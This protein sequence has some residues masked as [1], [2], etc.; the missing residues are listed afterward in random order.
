[1]SGSQVAYVVGMLVEH[2]KRPAW[3]PG[4]VLAIGGV[5]GKKITVYFRDF[6]EK[7]EENNLNRAVKKIDTT[8]VQL[9]VAD[10]QTDPMLDNL[11]PFTNNA[12]KSTKPRA[13]LEQ[14]ESIFL[15]YFPAGFKDPKYIERERAMK[16]RACSL[17]AD[18]LGD[19]KAEKLLKAGDI[20]EVRDLA[21][22]V[23]AETG[24]LLFL[25][26]S[27]AFR[28]GLKDDEA[29]HRF[30]KALFTLLSSGLDEERF[31]A[32]KEA[33]QLMPVEG[34]TGPVK[35]TVATIL[36]FLAQPHRHFFMKPESIKA[37]AE[38]LR[39]DIQ[40]RPDPNWITYSKVL[41]LANLLLARLRHLGA[42]DMI[43]VQTFMYVIWADWKWGILYNE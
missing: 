37:G 35:W 7:N 23:L 2:P 3:G 18:T 31:D 13:S 15:K 33:L 40:Y 9:R 4:K 20:G 30:F 21:L 39:F 36:P 6:E 1:M 10:I 29:A 25:T 5:D 16:L 38:L 28:D 17:Y 34:K 42:S 24:F 43:D 26:E 27:M 12:F 14:G 32:L 11:P 8:K 41:E 22:K 19:G